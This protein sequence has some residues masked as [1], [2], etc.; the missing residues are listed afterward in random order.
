MRQ[1]AAVHTEDDRDHAMVGRY[2]TQERELRG[3]SR[4]EVARV[5]KIAPN[6]LDA[7]ETGDPKRLPAKG[8]LVGYLKSYAAAIGLDPDDVVLRW[9]ESEGIDGGEDSVSHPRLS[10]LKLRYRVILWVLAC[11]ILGAGIV[12]LLRG[13]GGDAVRVF[14]SKNAERG[15]YFNPN[16]PTYAPAAPPPPSA[17]PTPAEPIA[18]APVEATPEP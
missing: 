7:I 10:R 12:F 5:T 2:L 15:A 16:D 4:A 18:P 3:L 6:V 14:R 11:A 17:E 13:G 1:T 9:H 8:Y